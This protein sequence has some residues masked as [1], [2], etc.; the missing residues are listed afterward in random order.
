MKGRIVHSPDKTQALLDELKEKTEKL[1]LTNTE[2]EQVIKLE[3][4]IVI[5]LDLLAKEVNQ[6]TYHVYESDKIIN[7][8]KGLC[9]ALQQSSEIRLRKIAVKNEHQSHLDNTTKSKANVEG[10]INDY[11]SKHKHTL[12]QKEETINL[13]KERLDEILQVITNSNEGIKFQLQNNSLY[14]QKVK[15]ITIA[16]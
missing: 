4:E 14:D 7:K 6:H 13:E 9:Q 12:E 16:R 15:F 8:L 10:I 2:L 1:K 11:I 3:D 5:N